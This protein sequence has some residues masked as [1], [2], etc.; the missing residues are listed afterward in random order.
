M[1]H[2]CVWTSAERPEPC[3]VSA[4]L[5]LVRVIVMACTV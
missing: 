5:A 4:G 2:V 3:V 1:V